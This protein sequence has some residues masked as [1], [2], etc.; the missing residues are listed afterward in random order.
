MSGS[1]NPVP[2]AKA[3]D[4]SPKGAFYEPDTKLTKK[5]KRAAARS[6]QVPEESSL[7]LRRSRIS[8]S[9]NEEKTAAAFQKTHAKKRVTLETRTPPPPSK[10]EKIEPPVSK[11]E[12]PKKLHRTRKSKSPKGLQALYLFFVGI[13]S[14]IGTFL[15]SLFKMFRT[16]PEDSNAAIEVS[17]KKPL[18]NSSAKKEDLEDH[19]LRAGINESALDIPDKNI[20]G[21]KLIDSIKDGVLGFENPD[22]PLPLSPAAAEQIDSL[23]QSPYNIGRWR[24]VAGDGNCYYRAVMFGLM[25]QIIKNGNRERFSELARIFEAIT[26]S[27]HES[28][29][30]SLKGAASGD[31]WGTLDDFKRDVIDLET[32]LDQNMVCAARDLI[33]SEIEKM[34]GQIL[35]EHGLTI[36]SLIENEP[37]QDYCTRIRTLGAYAEGPLVNMGLLG[38]ALGF[39]LTSYTI[40]GNSLFVTRQERDSSRQEREKV[41]ILLVDEREHYVLVYPKP[42]RA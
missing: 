20:Y 10:C 40:S 19:E 1:I 24:P 2:S 17:Q 39:S 29:I 3:P 6:L 22:K 26:P 7:S 35:D 25:E 15:Y 34:K 36:E 27:V 14:F 28:F 32:G 23:K 5:T 4:D 31:K 12:K 13:C 9:S 30:A 21:S 37:L 38:Q 11:S 16:Q 42:T 18:I 33:A 8:T 41:F